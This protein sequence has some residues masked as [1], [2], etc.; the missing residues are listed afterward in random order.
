MVSEI[1]PA[2][3]KLQL[4]LQAL[5]FSHIHEIAPLLS[6]LREIAKPPYVSTNAPQY[7]VIRTRPVF[8]SCK[9]Q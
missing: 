1:L 8:S 5:L 7:T 4:I 9:Q 3:P 6:G 2:L